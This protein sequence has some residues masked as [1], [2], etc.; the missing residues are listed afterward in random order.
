M[1]GEPFDQLVLRYFDHD[2][3]DREFAILQDTL[4]N[5]ADARR[6]PEAHDGGR[7]VLLET[8]RGLELPERARMLRRARLAETHDGQGV[9]QPRH[10]RRGGRRRPR[11]QQGGHGGGKAPPVLEEEVVVRPAHTPL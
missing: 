2:L 6:R 7:L 10:F 11:R 1:T 8:E 5:S 4:A 9:E 3:S